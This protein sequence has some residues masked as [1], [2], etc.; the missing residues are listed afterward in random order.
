[1]AIAF[2]DVSSA[3]TSAT[4]TSFDHVCAGSDRVLYVF[5]GVDA[6]IDFGPA[7]TYNG[8]SLTS[9]AEVSGTD[10][11]YQACFRLVAPATGTNS[12]SVTSLPGGGPQTIVSISF[13]GVD[14]STPDDTPVTSVPLTPFTSI[15]GDVTTPSGDLALAGVVINGDVSATLAEGAGQTEPAGVPI[16]AS[17]QLTASV[18]YE[19]GTGTTTMD[20]TWTGGQGGS[21]I[22]LNINAAGGGGVVM[23]PTIPAKFVRGARVSRKRRAA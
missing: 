22:A 11:R 6:A 13:T 12:V 10:S 3:T 9:I 4:S 1:M 23:P 19:A 14:Q 2:D 18:S 16:V 5:I 8:V 15:T 17:T 7:V 21:Q 20:W